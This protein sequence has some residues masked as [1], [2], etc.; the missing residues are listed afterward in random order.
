MELTNVLLR[1]L[2]TEKSMQLMGET[3]QVAFQVHSDANKLEIQRA[4]EKIFNV[5]V[6]AVRIVCRAPR[7]RTRQGRVV[8]RKSGFKKAYVT[9][10]Q[11][12][13]ISLFEGA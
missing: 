8:G 4:V 7:D 12:D 10:R 1:P 11:G 5:G 9:L 6:D 2:L 13:K 3:R